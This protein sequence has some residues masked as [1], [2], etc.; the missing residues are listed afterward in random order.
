MSLIFTW[1]A[2]DS[3]I[4]DCSGVGMKWEGGEQNIIRLEWG[5]IESMY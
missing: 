5:D 3:Y 4:I 1:R 2:A